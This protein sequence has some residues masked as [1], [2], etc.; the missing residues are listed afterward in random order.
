M[1][2]FSKAVWTLFVMSLTTKWLWGKSRADCQLKA[3]ADVHLT[4]V[5]CQSEVHCIDYPP[6]SQTY[7]QQES[8]W[9]GTVCDW[10]KSAEARAGSVIIYV[11]Y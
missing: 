7:P 2:E 6:P 8:P 10:V 4:M 11:N 3:V 9:L 1:F 5:M